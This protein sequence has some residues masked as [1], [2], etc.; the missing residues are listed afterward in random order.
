MGKSFSDE[1]YLIIR[2]AIS[3]KL[4]VHIQEE[5][6]NYLDDFNHNKN[7]DKKKAFKD[8]NFVILIND[9]FYEDSAINLRNELLKKTKLNNIL[10]KKINDN[11]YRLLA[12]PFKNFNALKTTYISLNNSGFEDLNIYKD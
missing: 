11:K 9:F 3:R 5:I 7:K 8:N 6:S 10:I 2:N 4:L 12:G 1:G